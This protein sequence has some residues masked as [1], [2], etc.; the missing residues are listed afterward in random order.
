MLTENKFSNYLLYAVGEIILVVVGILIALQINN[1]NEQRIVNNKEQVLLIALRQEFNGNQK[2]LQKVIEINRSNIEGAKKFSSLFSPN[3]IN[4]S[5]TLIS[6]YFGQAL[7][8][9]AIF[10][11]S[12]G[13]LNEAINSGNLSIIK[14]TKL[15]SIL[16]SFDA[17]LQQL[18]QQEE[19]VYEQRIVSFRTFESIGNF[20]TI[21]GNIKNAL[22]SYQL[23]KSHFQGSNIELL[24]SERFENNIVMFLG[25]SMYLEGSFLIP[26]DNRISEC[27][28]ILNAEINEKNKKAQHRV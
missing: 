23:T 8:S 11:P 10:R 21:L 3:A 9:E 7:M 26:L 25:T 12:L 17:E 14:N 1:W 4:V 24:H 5:D 16:S 27:I 20:K 2:V 19:A 6:N 15:R 22:S 18:R 28:E 13:I